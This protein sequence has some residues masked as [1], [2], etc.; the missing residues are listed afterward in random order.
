MF[1]TTG[2]PISAQTGTKSYCAFEDGVI[3]QALPGTITLI[4][5]EA[6]CEALSPIAN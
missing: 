6:A 1:Y 2:Y 5:S 4:G 3:R